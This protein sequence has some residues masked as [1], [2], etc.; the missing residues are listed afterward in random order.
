MRKL[1]ARQKQILEN[2]HR[3]MADN[4]YPPTVREI[5]SSFDFSS[6]RAASDHLKALQKKGY[7]SKKSLSRSI[8]LTPKA[9][10]PAGLSGEEGMLKVPL[11]GSI[12]AGLPMLAEQNIETYLDLP[13]DPKNRKVDFALKVAG[14]SMTGDHIKDGDII[15]VRAQDTAENG[16]IVVALLGE[17]ATVKRL[18]FREEAI[19]LRPSNPSYEPIKVNED[20]KIQGKVLSVYRV[21]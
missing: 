6:P 13:P 1:T 14:E 21:L 20:V 4:G 7:I 11:I 12:A 10:G 17:Q 3:F 8:R 2:I 18:Q 15:L 19:I 5:A 16:D 9:F